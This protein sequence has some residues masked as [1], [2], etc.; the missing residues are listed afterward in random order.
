MHHRTHVPSSNEDGDTFDLRVETVHVP[1]LLDKLTEILAL[2]NV[3][4]HVRLLLAP[5]DLDV[6]STVVCRSLDQ[7]LHYTTLRV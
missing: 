3:L 2:S 6:Q 5:G 1:E 7:L 4:K